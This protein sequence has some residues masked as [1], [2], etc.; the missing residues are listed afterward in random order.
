VIGEV[1]ND[2][3]TKLWREG[4]CIL[5][6]PQNKLILLVEANV[7][8]THMLGVMKDILAAKMG[9]EEDLS[10]LELTKRMKIYTGLRAILHD[11]G[12]SELT[13]KINLEEKKGESS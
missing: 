8:R 2:W 11:M 7:A 1:D 9:K 3:I 13:E 10:V 6:T 4:R 5:P 12:I